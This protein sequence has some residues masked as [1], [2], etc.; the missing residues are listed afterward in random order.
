MTS[1]DSILPLPAGAASPDD[2]KLSQSQVDS[3]MHGIHARGDRLLTRFI[4]G[5]AVLTVALAPLYDTWTVS[6]VWGAISLAAWLAAIR[7]APGSFLTRAM[8]GVVLESFCAL[9]IWQMH[10]QPEQHFWF[11]VGFTMMIVYQ[12]WI[13]MW[14]GALL[15]IAQ[16][17]AFA[18]LHNRGLNLHFF[19]EAHVDFIKLLFHFGIA[20]VH[21][22]VCGYWGWLL[23]RQTLRDASQKAQLVE[24]QATIERQ[25]AVSMASEA[26]LLHTTAELRTAESELKAD[27]E[28]R[29]RVEDALRESQEGLRM[30]LD[31]AQMASWE[32]E[33]STGRLSYSTGGE[34]LFGPG[35]V[36]TPR[37]LSELLQRV[38]LEDRDRVES[39]FRDAA[40]GG[41]GERRTI[42][43]R[44]NRPNGEVRWVIQQGQAQPPADGAESRMLG[45][46]GDVTDRREEE[47]RHRQLELR[48]QHAQKLESL[49][50]L[51]GGI[52]HDFNNI[53]VGILGN[54]SL[55]LEELPPG[56]PTTATVKDIETAALRAAE[57]TRHML[58][59]SGHGKFV[60]ERLLL[61]DR[62]RE[63]TPLL[64]SMIAKTT[65]L[66]LMLPDED[67]PIEADGSQIDQVI[68]NLATNASEALGAAAG[69][70]V[71]TTGALDVSRQFLDGI[72]YAE[73]LEPG[74]Y[75]FLR[76]EDSGCG[77]S[78]ATV[79]RIFD[80]FFT[81]KF[82]GR[83]L[84]MAAVLG[85][86]RGHHGAIRVETSLGRGS[87]FTVLFPVA[88]PLRLPPRPAAPSCAADDWQGAGLVLVIDDEA[89][90]RRLAT[91]VL[92]QR[93][94]VVKAARNGIEGLQ[95]FERHQT[96]VTL[97]LL[98]RTMPGLSGEE[99]LARIRQLR[100]ETRVLLSSGYTEDSED[101]RALA[102]GAAGFIAKPYKS[103]QLITAVR[104]VLDAVPR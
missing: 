34:A 20:I 87:R 60:V 96:D 102:S 100:R 37:S 21:V 1:I 9:H 11:F 81:T 23:R 85:I 63:L 77:M 57:L 41:G 83:G 66:R 92:E 79:E 67:V 103:R 39:W 17:L 65:D 88:A 82:T 28:D 25:L 27:I 51:A 55:A 72:R 15:I 43:Y 33:L 53:L 2:T 61:A 22:G 70:V 68:M 44:V 89:S 54:A 69:T 76:V 78:E 16:H 74:R 7:F 75:A 52:A 18:V 56:A 48:M 97:V 8:A 50:V 42:Q 31:A 35:T 80:P 38:D 93:G 58:A 19:P 40:R 86:I 5:H 46:L 36:V 71:V 84:G 73:N 90:I 3:I 91:R 94:F 29:R 59:Y 62:V 30:A 6:L 95:L 98:D 64:L 45:V 12:D 26:T 24:S 10:G 14:P 99:V 101:E 49:G 4:A 13:C 104:R 47:D 32:L